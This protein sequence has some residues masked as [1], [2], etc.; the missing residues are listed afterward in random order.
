LPIITIAGPTVAN[1]NDR[2]NNDCDTNTGNIFTGSMVPTNKL[3]E[4]S[5]EGNKRRPLTNPT[6]IEI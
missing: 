2:N 4:K 1:K 6:I 3:L 5:G